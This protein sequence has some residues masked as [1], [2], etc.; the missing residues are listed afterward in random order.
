MQLY[1]EQCRE[2]R[3]SLSDVNN[4]GGRAYVYANVFCN[5]NVLWLTNSLNIASKHACTHKNTP[6]HL[7]SLHNGFSL[8]RYAGTSVAIACTASSNNPLPHSVELEATVTGCPCLWEHIEHNYTDVCDG[9]IASCF[10]VIERYMLR[11][12]ECHL[13]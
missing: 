12:G 13:Y 2:S 3:D 9:L 5:S 7:L 11:S 10:L 8:P 4:I 6:T 1:C